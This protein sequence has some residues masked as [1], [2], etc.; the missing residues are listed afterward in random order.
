MENH[1]FQQSQNPE[2]HNEHESIERVPEALMGKSYD[3]L[4]TC[5]EDSK[6]SNHCCGQNCG[7]SFCS[8]AI[9]QKAIEKAPNLE[10]DFVVL[11]KILTSANFD[12]YKRRMLVKKWLEKSIS[13][14][15]SKED[16]Q[17]ILDSF[18]NIKNSFSEISIDDVLEK[19][20][21]D[22][23]NKLEK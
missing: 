16:L 17:L 1:N 20:E 6:A 15:D 10:E 21:I 22:I 11:D 23:K 9:L 2:S 8:R 7:T 5:Y 19:Y 12:D 4:L 13:R 18:E 3:Q 14:Y